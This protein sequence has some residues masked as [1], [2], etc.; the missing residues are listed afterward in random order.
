MFSDR[1]VN[2]EKKYKNVLYCKDENSI[3]NIYLIGNEL[4]NIDISKRSEMLE[5]WFYIYIQAV[6]VSKKY[7][8]TSYNMHIDFNNCPIMDLQRPVKLFKYLNNELSSKFPSEK[9]LNK[10]CIYSKSKVIKMVYL[11]VLKVVN[12]D[13]KKKLQLFECESNNV[14]K[15]NNINLSVA[16]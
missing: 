10:C 8:K 15:H 14:I 9:Y 5:Y 4:K 13:V 12:N 6:N 1:Y 16:I 11:L 2:L 3:G 7:N